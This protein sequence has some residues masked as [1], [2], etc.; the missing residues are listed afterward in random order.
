M[1]P[2]VHH[3]LQGLQIISNLNLRAVSLS[4]M[5]LGWKLSTLSITYQ[6]NLLIVVPAATSSKNAFL[7]CQ[8]AFFHSTLVQYLPNSPIAHLALGFE[9]FTVYK[10][11]LNNLVSGGDRRLRHYLPPR[12]ELA[13]GTNSSKCL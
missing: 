8:G 2:Q 4:P 3:H 6:C 1:A 13:L 10:M 7:T 12:F 11:L 9:L 5:A